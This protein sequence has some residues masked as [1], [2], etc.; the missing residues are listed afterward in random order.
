[1]Q[2]GESMGKNQSNITLT[3]PASIILDKNIPNP[4][5]ETTIIP[6][7][8]DE[9]FSRAEIIFYNADGRKINTH[10]ITSMGEGQLTVFADDLSSG[11]YTYVLVVDGKV[12]DSKKMVKR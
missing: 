12:I 11:I 4:M 7:R 9:N 5:E 1:M 2:S 6:F 3:N 8:I 10:L